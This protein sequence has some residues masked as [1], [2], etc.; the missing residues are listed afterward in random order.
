MMPVLLDAALSSIQY[1]I[2]TDPALKVP[3]ELAALL[4]QFVTQRSPGGV[5]WVGLICRHPAD[6]ARKWY[7]PPRA[8]IRVGYR[9]GERHQWL[10]SSSHDRGWAMRRVETI[11]RLLL[12][13]LAL[14]VAKCSPLKPQDK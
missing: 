5:E 10:I 7:E 6:P 14:E 13:R 4:P 3:P 8:Y 2:N 9:F 1:S 12:K 11:L